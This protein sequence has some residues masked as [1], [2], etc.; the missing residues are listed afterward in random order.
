[1]MAHCVAPQQSFMMATL[2]LVMD[3]L[4]GGGSGVCFFT[5]GGPEENIQG[6]MIDYS[7]M[8]KGCRQ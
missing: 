1:M 8:S 6:N 7:H 5:F 3:G 2:L 4:F